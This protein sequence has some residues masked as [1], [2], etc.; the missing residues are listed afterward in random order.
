MPERGSFSNKAV[1][2]EVAGIAYKD[3]RPVAY[4]EDNVVKESA[5]PGSNEKLGLILTCVEQGQEV[6]SEIYALNTDKYTILAVVEGAR[7]VN[8]VAYQL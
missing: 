2:S 6:E 8:V 3:G 1:I 5:L 4:I 7:I